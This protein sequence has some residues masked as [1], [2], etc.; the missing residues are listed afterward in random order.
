MTSFQALRTKAYRQSD[1]AGA[2]QDGT[3][4]KSEFRA[5]GQHHKKYEDCF[6]DTANDESKRFGPLF[7]TR[8]AEHIA[9]RNQQT[10]AGQSRVDQFQYDVRD[11]DDAGNANGKNHDW[12]V[13]SS[14]DLT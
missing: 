8:H 12:R 11:N 7:N 10:Q 9:G 5:D 2:G 13:D 14:K 3:D 4:I 1:D 6:A